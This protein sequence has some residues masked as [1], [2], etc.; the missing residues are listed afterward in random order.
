VCP[1][2]KDKANIKCM[3]SVGG[4][5]PTKPKVCSFISIL[6]HIE[7]DKVVYVLCSTWVIG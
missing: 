2:H 1:A 6:K 5:A 7:Q 3:G 4:K